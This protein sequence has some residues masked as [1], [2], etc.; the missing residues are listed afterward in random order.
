ALDGL[1]PGWPWRLRS[2]PLTCSRLRAPIVLAHGLFGFTRIALGPLTLAAYFRGIPDVMR[3]AG[4]RVLV[5]RVHPTAGIRRRGRKLGERSEAAFGDEPVHIIAH[6]MGGLDARVLLS[7]PAWS[8]RILSLTT[9]GTPHLGSPLADFAKVR[10]GRIY[11]LLEA[12]GLD[13]RGFFD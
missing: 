5:T 7:D 9:I 12:V 2:T 13:H 6:S 8:G 1:G 11:R 3:A 10:A 4:N